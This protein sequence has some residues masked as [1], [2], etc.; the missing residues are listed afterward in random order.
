MEVDEMPIEE[1]EEI[2]RVE[3]Q[4]ISTEEVKKGIGKDGKKTRDRK[5]NKYA[6]EWMKILQGSSNAIFVNDYEFRDP[7]S[8][9]RDFICHDTNGYEFFMYFFYNRVKKVPICNP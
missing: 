6:L 7:N 4:E 1:V 5:P 9:Y 2:P 3:V 8:F